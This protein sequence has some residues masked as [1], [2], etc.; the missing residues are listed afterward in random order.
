[1]GLTESQPTITSA[2]SLPLRFMSPALFSSSATSPRPPSSTTTLDPCE[3]N[4]QD[5]D[6]DDIGV[7]LRQLNDFVATNGQTVPPSLTSNRQTGNTSD[8]SETERYLRLVNVVPEAGETGNDDDNVKHSAKHQEIRTAPLFSH[9]VRNAL[10]RGKLKGYL[11]G[12]EDAFPQYGLLG[13]REETRGRK[14]QHVEDCAKLTP[15]QNLVFANMNAPWSALIC[16]SQGSG[17]SH[18]LSCLLENSLLSSSPA[19]ILPNPLAGLV[20]HYDKYTSHASTQVCEAAYLC[21]AGIPVRVL[22]S[23]SNIH[24]MHHLYTNLAGLPKNAPRPQVL[25][26]YFREDQL[27]VSRMVALMAVNDG[28][29]N[30]TPLYI[31]VLYKILRDMASEAKGAP[32]LNYM[33]FRR[34]LL[35][36]NFTPNQIAPLQLRLGLLESFLAHPTQEASLA[37]SSAGNIFRSDQGTLTIVDLSCPFVNENDACSL[38]T[39]CLSLFM[40]NRGEGGRIVALDEAHKV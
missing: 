1:L 23:P 12:L 32:G 4:E 15:E 19:G 7:R 24:N 20:F 3:T 13:I 21:S 14:D 29:Q 16:G 17:K 27:N 31:E 40:E 30:K 33:D 2:V 36:E 11:A 9:Q 25:P 26:L 28:S 22:V 34:R 8:V 18:T 5:D 10:Q 6:D 37:S 39:M 35:S 38:F